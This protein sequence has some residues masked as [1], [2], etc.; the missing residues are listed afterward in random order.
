MKTLLALLLLI[1]NL[2]WGLT[3]KDGKQVDSDQS[4]LKDYDTNIE[5]KINNP[6]QVFLPLDQLQS[7]IDFYKS[8]NSA[9]ICEHDEDGWR[10]RGD[11]ER[12]LQRLQ[13]VPQAGARNA[14]FQLHVDLL[15]VAQGRE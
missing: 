9:F 5:W 12:Q 3:F 14:F 4:T 2:S 13:P 6:Y 15:R 7:N 11:S 10:S 1:P 8:S